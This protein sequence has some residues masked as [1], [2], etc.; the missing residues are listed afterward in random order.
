[1]VETAK[2]II[3]DEY[4]EGEYTLTLFDASGKTW[5]SMRGEKSELIIERG[6]MP[7][8]IYFYKISNKKGRAITGPIVFK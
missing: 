2:F 7:S 6:T 4:I 5:K 1:M 3:G 8:G